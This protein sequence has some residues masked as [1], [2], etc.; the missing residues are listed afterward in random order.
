MYKIILTILISI[1]MLPKAFS[2]TK[3]TIAVEAFK[4]QPI[5]VT[6]QNYLQAKWSGDLT[7]IGNTFAASFTEK[8]RKAG[9]TVVTRRSI[10]SLLDENRLAQQGI[11]DDE[12]TTKL[13]TADFRI[14]GTIQQFEESEKS[15][16]VL[17]IVGGIAGRKVTQMQGDVLISVELI[18]R[19]GTILATATGK[20]SKTG[21]IND[22]SGLATKIDGKFFAI[23]NNSNKGAFS[24][25]ITNASNHSIELAVKDLS[26]QLRNINL[27]TYK[28][29][30]TETSPINNVDLTGIRFVVS[31]PDSPVAEE[32]FVDYL[33][34]AKARIILGASFDRNLFHNN[35]ALESYCLNL[36]KNSGNAKYFVFG[37]IDSDRVN[38]QT[39]RISMSIKI[40]DMT[41]FQL[42][43]SES[44]QGSSIDI[45]NK[46]GMDRVVKET[47]NKLLNSSMNKLIAYNQNSIE[48]SNSVYSL[49]LTGFQSLS[50]AN[51]FIKI[52]IKNDNVESCEVVDFSNKTL[53]AEIKFKNKANYTETLEKDNDL[54]E[55]FLVSVKSVT[56]N[57]IIGDVIIR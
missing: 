32:V 36:R 8:L 3:P 2:Q 54:L 9:Y 17:G 12:G 42:V 11:V 46:A 44:A 30:K 1:L 34:S 18:A 28:T 27:N 20:S 52:L 25:A 24:E 13:R 39:N 14:V 4:M 23:L 50:S 51:R 5:S 15:N 7:T 6:T 26:T 31:F 33:S 19:D 16:G 41:N 22:T 45:S 37:I 29:T 35:N 43:H 38:N 47:T 10:D 57:K 55:M 40:I 49:E 48:K 53:F 56:N 21:R